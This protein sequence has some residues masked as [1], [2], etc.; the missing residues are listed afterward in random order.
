MKKRTFF[1]PFGFFLVVLLL[2]ANALVA[3]ESKSVTPEEGIS[4]LAPL[5]GYPKS[6]LPP[7]EKTILPPLPPIP[8]TPPSVPENRGA[9][10]PR[11]GERYPP[12]GRGA[13]DPATG[14]YYP[15]SGKGFFNPRTGEYY[16]PVDP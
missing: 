11:T 5:E 15:P 16:P 10:N 9:F 6:P 4:Q 13:L 12:S 7:K 8:A 2:S 1:L 3:A 14:E